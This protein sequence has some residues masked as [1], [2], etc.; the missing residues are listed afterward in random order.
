MGKSHYTEEQISFVPRQAEL[1]TPVA[2]VC[3]KMGVSEATFFRWTRKL[4]LLRL[5]CTVP[6]CDV[7][8]CA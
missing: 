6:G 3:R 8:G 7:T 1:R 2:E 5:R 4:D